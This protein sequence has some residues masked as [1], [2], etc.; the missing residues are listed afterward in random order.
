MGVFLA[1]VGCL[2]SGRQAGG[3]ELD[4]AKPGLWGAGGKVK[5][6]HLFIQQK[7]PGTQQERSWLKAPVPWSAHAREGCRQGKGEMKTLCSRPESAQTKAE[8]K[9]GRGL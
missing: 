6:A 3:E 1:A 5:R 4:S 7:A 8:R 9:G 2:G